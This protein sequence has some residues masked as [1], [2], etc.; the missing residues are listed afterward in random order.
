MKAKIIIILIV[1]FFSCKKQAET[2]KPATPIKKIKSII[3]Y[4]Y[5]SRYVSI[6]SNKLSEK[7]VEL[8]DTNGVCVDR[9]KYYRYQITP[10]F[11]EYGPRIVKILKDTNKVVYHFWKEFKKDTI[12]EYE[13]SI[14]FEYMSFLNTDR[15]R[16]DQKRVYVKG[17]LI[18]NSLFNNDNKYTYINKKPV[19]IPS[20][21][22]KFYQ[23]DTNGKLIK[24][25]TLYKNK[26]STTETIY[27]GTTL[28]KIVERDDAT[29][30]VLYTEEYAFDKKNRKISQIETSYTKNKKTVYNRYYSYNSRD[31]LTQSRFLMDN[32]LFLKQEYVYNPDGKL[33][34]EKDFDEFTKNDT[35]HLSV[36]TEYYYNDHHK[37]AHKAIFYSN[38]ETPTFLRYYHYDKNHNLSE[39][40]LFSDT[41]NT[42]DMSNDG[43]FHFNR[44]TIRYY[45]KYYDNQQNK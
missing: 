19:V 45:Y 6:D 44:T 36:Q 43:K 20:P 29:K 40:I 34:L 10:Y 22:S 17:K 32:K 18:E 13:E 12:I 4:T 27:K 7:R 24:T 42:E 25:K 37:L 5:H 8:F 39:V 33:Q 15:L 23:Y 35:M 2:K 1:V 38:N 28:K 14:D 26:W 30:A 3:S 21:F 11:K 16:L 9:K 41:K 31:S